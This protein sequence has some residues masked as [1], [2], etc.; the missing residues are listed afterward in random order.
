MGY[1]ADT[2][3]ADALAADPELIGR[4]VALNPSFQLLQDPDSFAQ[5]GNAV[6]L[7]EAA[8]VV[9]VPLADLL[10]AA[11][12]QS[13]VQC[14]AAYGDAPDEERPIWMN[15]FEEETAHRVDV[16]PVIAAGHEPFTAIMTAAAAVPEEGGLIIDAPF[17]PMPLRGMLKRKGFASYAGHLAPD[18]W[19]VYCL[20]GESYAKDLPPIP[21]QFGAP[22][23]R[24]DDG[25]HIDVRSLEAPAPLMAILALVDGPDHGGLVTVHHRRDP[26]YLYPELAERGWSWQRIPGEQ[27]EIR[28]LLRK[29][30]TD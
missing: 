30:A 18:H 23:W 27:G 22:I 25:V 21:S 14:Q 16:R 29:E 8:G 24:A 10:M 2:R 13:P 1:S 19:R 26:L 4:L 5:L 3:V 20:R 15:R 28:L 11:N 12:A 6:T 7:K 9:G 17:N